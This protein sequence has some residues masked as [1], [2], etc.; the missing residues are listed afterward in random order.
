MPKQ[1]NIN[2]PIKP[3]MADISQKQVMSKKS[4]QLSK[5]IDILSLYINNYNK[6]LTGREIA[7]QI[8]INHQTALNKLNQLVNSNIL[9]YEKSGNSK[10]YSLIQNYK[11]RLFLFLTETISSFSALNNIELSILIPELIPCCES[12]ILF[13]SFS[14][15]T[16]DKKSD[17]D[18]IIIGKCDKNKI[19]SIKE[20]HT[21]SIN[22]EYI[23]WKG[24]ESA[25]YNKN[26]LAKEILINHKLFGNIDKIVNI[27]WGYY[28]G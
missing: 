12:I 2:K 22:I 26:P 5:N 10:Y 9:Y 14:S 1:K 28:F 8:S 6:R 25:I 16:Y 15:N 11:T 24:L 18:L 13:G 23:S 7:R 20:R 21:R 4:R 19:N 27:F 3:N 17:I